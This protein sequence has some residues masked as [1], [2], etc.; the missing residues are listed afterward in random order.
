MRIHAEPDPQPCLKLSWDPECWYRYYFSR[1]WKR[2][3]V[4]ALGKKRVGDEIPVIP[5]QSK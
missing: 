3:R 1:W 2:G 4:K 5:N